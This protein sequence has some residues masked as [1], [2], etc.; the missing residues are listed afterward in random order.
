VFKGVK[1]IRTGKQVEIIGGLAGETLTAKRMGV[2]CE[3]VGRSG[4][5]EETKNDK[6]SNA[7]ILKSLF[8]TNLK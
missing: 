7:P 5:R 2:N 3:T 1:T 4:D 8:A 6:L